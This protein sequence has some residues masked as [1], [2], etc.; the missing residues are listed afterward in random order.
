MLSTA[1]SLSPNFHNWADIS[2]ENK[3]TIEMIGRT[4]YVI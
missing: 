4:Y 3:V 2:E 1:D